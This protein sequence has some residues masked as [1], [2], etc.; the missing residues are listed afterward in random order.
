M[1]SLHFTKYIRMDDKSAEKMLIQMGIH[2]AKPTDIRDCLAELSGYKPVPPDDPEELIKHLESRCRLNQ[3]TTPP[4]IEITNDDGT[5]SLM[6][7]TW[8]SAGTSQKVA[9]GFGGSMRE[10][11]TGK[12]DG[13]RAPK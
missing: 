3:E 11:I 9:A 4:S 1:E 12:T 6:E 2:G 5:Q 7:D 13:R 8:R 10:C